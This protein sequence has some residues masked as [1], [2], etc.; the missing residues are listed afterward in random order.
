MKGFLSA[1]NVMIISCNLKQ[2][3]ACLRHQWAYSCEKAKRELNYKPRSLT[4]GLEEVLPWL[5]NLG[6]IKY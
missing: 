5:K 2:V 3:V 4:E 6:A 1:Y